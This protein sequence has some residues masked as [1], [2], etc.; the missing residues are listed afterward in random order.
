MGIA[1][2][3]K[4]ERP[5]AASQHDALVVENRNVG[6][7]ERPDDG[8]KVRSPLV[9]AEH[10]EDACGAESL[11]KCATMVSIGIGVPKGHRQ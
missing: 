7:F 1:D 9:V 10:G 6:R 11:P 3:G 8:T 5:A 2:T 4:I